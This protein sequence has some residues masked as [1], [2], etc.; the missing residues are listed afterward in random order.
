MWRKRTLFTYLFFNSLHYYHYI[1]FYNF[2]SDA[3]KIVHCATSVKWWALGHDWESE[4]HL[5]DCRFGRTEQGPVSV[6]SLQ[7]LIFLKWLFN[8]FST[9]RSIFCN[10]NEHMFNKIISRV[11]R[12]PQLVFDRNNILWIV[13]C[14]NKV[15][16]FADFMHLQISLHRYFL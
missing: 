6:S 16:H 7:L 2:I 8:V 5:P 11:R 9:E 14:Y 1:H 4:Q 15:F 10:L 12:S 3:I 13:L